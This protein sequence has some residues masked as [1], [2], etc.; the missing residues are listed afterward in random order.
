MSFLA[1][2]LIVSAEIAAGWLWLER[3]VEAAG[4]LLLFW[5]WFT[6]VVLIVGAGLIVAAREKKA[7]TAPKRDPRPVRWA[8]RVVAV[9]RVV[10]MVA[11]DHPVLASFYLIAWTVSWAVQLESK[12]TNAEGA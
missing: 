9:V 11:L 5:W 2:F 3:G 4:R 8:M 7:Y 1:R 12:K 10:C 6:V